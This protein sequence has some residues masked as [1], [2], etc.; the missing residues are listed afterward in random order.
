VSGPSAYGIVVASARLVLGTDGELI[1]FQARDCLGVSAA[2]L[3]PIVDGINGWKLFCTQPDS[4]ASLLIPIVTWGRGAAE[5]GDPVFAFPAVAQSAVGFGPLP[6]FSWTI[7]LSDTSGNPIDPKTVMIPDS[8][9]S[10]IYFCAVT[11]GT[12]QFLHLI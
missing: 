11:N 9:Y 8:P 6:P 12:D 3:D 2:S 10:S 1:V 5:S 7:W 4:V